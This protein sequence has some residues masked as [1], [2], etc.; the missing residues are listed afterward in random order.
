METKFQNPKVNEL[1]ENPNKVYGGIASIAVGSKFTLPESI[2]DENLLVRESVTTYKN[3][4]ELEDKVKSDTGRSAF[5]KVEGSESWER[6][7][8]YLVIA[9]PEGDL[10]LGT[11]CSA[12]AAVTSN[13]T[14]ADIKKVAATSVTANV[15]GR[16]K[17]V[18]AWVEKNPGLELNVTTRTD[19]EISTNTAGNLTLTLT[20]FNGESEPKKKGKKA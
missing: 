4:R 15:R 13:R 1:L 11:L 19:Y 5:H 7:V 6:R 2:N 12:A 17:Q 10:A 8:N 3:R 18:L 20:V 14:P 16:A 9:C